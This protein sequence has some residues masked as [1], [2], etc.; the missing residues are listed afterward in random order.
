MTEKFTWHIGKVDSEADAK[1]LRRCIAEA[2]MQIFKHNIVCSPLNSEG[3]ISVDVEV[4]FDPNADLRHM[5]QE[6]A[7]ILAYFFRLHNQTQGRSVDLH[8][9]DYLDEAS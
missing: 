7:Q 3:K 6:L 8:L 9:H 4:E 2:K 1:T 5:H